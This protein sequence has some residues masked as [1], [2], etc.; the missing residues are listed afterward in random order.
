MSPAAAPAADAPALARW[1]RRWRALDASEQRW[2]LAAI[3]RLP[4][5]RLSLLLR[6]YQRSRARLEA[7]Y[8]PAGTRRAGADDLARAQRLA[9]LT[10]IAGRRG[11]VTATCLPQALL[12]YAALRR[13][14]LAPE[15]QIGV[16]KD[17][18]ALDAHA[19][20]ELEGVALGQSEVVHA[21]LP[22]GQDKASLAI[23]SARA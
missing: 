9:Q 10:A 22:L 6:G 20:V 17:G 11:L 16:R 19:W 15:L 7:R 3:F 2:L 14:G 5:I 23:R 13:Q 12:L 1:W 4:L 18:A 21:P 8:P